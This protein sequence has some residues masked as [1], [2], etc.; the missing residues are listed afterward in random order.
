LRSLTA[1]ADRERTR[2]FQPQAV[3]GCERVTATEEVKR[4]GTNNLHQPLGVPI[5]VDGWR[6]SNRQNTSG[7]RCKNGLTSGEAWERF[8][9]CSSHDERRKRPCEDWERSKEKKSC[10]FSWLLFFLFASGLWNGGFL[11]DWNSPAE[12][13]KRPKGDR[14]IASIL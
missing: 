1:T 4:S 14:L 10:H 5:E 3:K 8:C 7:D 11:A 6:L 12:Q 2:F 9:R 13:R